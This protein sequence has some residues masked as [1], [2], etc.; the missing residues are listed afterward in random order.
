VSVSRVGADLTLAIADDGV[1]FDVEGVRHNRDGLGLISIEERARQVKGQATI[2]SQPGC[3]TV[4]VVR[5]SVD[6]VA[7][8][9]GPLRDN[10]SMASVLRTGQSR[11][12][13]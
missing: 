6:G 1:G 9:S 12:I 5:V 2:H 7:E 11:T 8:P 3:G 10:R 13:E 4:I